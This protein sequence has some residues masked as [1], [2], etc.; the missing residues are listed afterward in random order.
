M[1]TTSNDDHC[2]PYL[3][4]PANEEKYPKLKEK[5]DRLLAS[6]NLIMWY[7]KNPCIK[8]DKLKPYPIG[9]KWQWKT[10]RFYGEN[11]FQHM[12]IYNSFGTNP[13]KLF[14][15]KSLKQNLLFF[16]FSQTTNNPLYTP[17]KNCRHK[18]KSESLKN[19]FTWNNNTA[20][21]DYM[22]VLKTYKFALA[23]PG[24]GIDTHRCWEALM[25]GTI[26][27]VLSS[28]INELYEGLPVVVVEDWSII[29]EEFLDKKYDEILKS[30]YDFRKVYCDYWVQKITG[31]NS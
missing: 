2:P 26:P 31:N 22:D 27:I 3:E 10:T 19:G 29:T 1:I 21:K 15:D 25:V 24:R 14:R 20:F 4:F 9:P 28:S 30:T 12:Q 17:H 13:D 8:H 16:N 18:V 6:S 5:T 23:P 7:A 11:K